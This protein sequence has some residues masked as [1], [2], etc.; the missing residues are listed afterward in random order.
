MSNLREAAMRLREQEEALAADYRLLENAAARDVERR[1]VGQILNFQ[2]LQL[3][4][5]ALLAD[6]VPEPFMGFGHIVAD[7]VNMREGPGGR[8]QAVDRLAKGTMVVIQGYSGYWVQVVVPGG[9][10]GFVF[11]DYVQQEMTT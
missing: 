11:K 9:R 3:A 1:V 10:G 6:G 7:D 2:R 5:L 4:S 8:Y